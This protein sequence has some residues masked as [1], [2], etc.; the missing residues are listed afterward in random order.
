[1]KKNLKEFRKREKYINEQKHDHLPLI[2]WNYKH[3]CQHDKAWDVYTRTTRGLVTDIEGNVIARP[4]P[5]FFNIGE[6][7]EAS[8]E[9]LPFEIPQITEKMDGSL[10]IQYYDNDLPSITTRGSFNS[11][12]AIFATEWIRARYRRDDFKEGYT[13]LYEIIYPE[14]RIVVDY[15]GEKKLTLLAIINIETG[16]E[17]D[18]K[19]EAE[20]L[21]ITYP[22]VFEGV[23]AEALD[24]MSS[25]P[26]NEEGFV[27]RYKNGLR[28]KMKGEE[29][30]R[31]HRLI[32]NFSTKSIWECLKNNQNLDSILQDVPDEF[33]IWTK[34]KETELKE[35]H[36]KLVSMAYKIHKKAN[37]FNTRKDQAMYV[38]EKTKE[39]RAVQ[40]LVFGY[41]DGKEVNK[42]AWKFLKPKY[43]LP[44]KTDIDS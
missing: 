10:G 41:L 1:M 19:E 39:N 23:L 16:E 30:I 3:S 6:I 14:N 24:M 8:L 9:N 35:R 22:K 31:L 20:R 40:A 43:E 11:D 29:Y 7:P 12:Q 37:E 21:K 15:R 13:Y 27:A 4:F 26:G 2:I 5:K 44:F 17:L 32:T 25:L 34:K 18:L 28:I 36:S 33:Y 38:Q 42:M